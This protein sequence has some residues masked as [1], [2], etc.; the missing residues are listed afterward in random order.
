MSEPSAAEL[1]ALAEHAARR[2]TLYRRRVYVGRGE[3]SRLAELQRVADGAAAR[4][5]RA[6]ERARGEVPPAGS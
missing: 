1:Q 3:P 5:G 6:R 2:V 4:A